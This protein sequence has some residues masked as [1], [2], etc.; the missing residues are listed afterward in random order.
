MRRSLIALSGCL[1]LLPTIAALHKNVIQ[2]SQQQQ[3]QQLPLIAMPDADYPIQPAVRLSDTLG[4][5]RALT[6][7]S[8][9]ARRHEAT[10][11]R[12]GSGADNTTVLAPLNEAIEA[13]PRKPWEDERDLKA[14]GAQVYEGDEGRD[15]ADRNM[16]RFVEAH[17]VM[18]SPWAEG[19][20]A[21][22]MAGTEV[23]WED[24]NGKRVIMPDKVEVDRVA[25]EVGN[26]QIVSY[27]RAFFTLCS[28]FLFFVFFWLTFFSFQWI[29]KGVL[30][31]P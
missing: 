15:R 5:N 19:E 30:K 31:S 18:Q 6:M 2:E 11:E 23:W 29:L 17:L 26:G 25:I 10:E 27:E 21:K 16:R 24:K 7:F 14:L 12:L 1:I 20:K 3:Q 22:T 28:C 8:S 4:S 13:L 9:F